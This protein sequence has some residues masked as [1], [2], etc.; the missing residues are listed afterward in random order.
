MAKNQRDIYETWRDTG[1]LPEIMTFI[2]DC[3]KKLV[4]QGEMC[5]HLG[6]NEAMFSRLKKRHPE[7]QFAMDKARMNLKEDLA[8]SLYKLAMRY[9][10][11]KETQD[12]EGKGSG[13]AQKRKIHRTKKEIGPDFKAIVYLLTKKFGREYSQRFEDF[14][15][16]EKKIEEAKEEWLNEQQTECSSDEDQCSP[17]LR[18]QSKEKR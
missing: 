10:F 4:T 7:I 12:I 17:R 14:Q 5:E 8:N 3:S 11:T 9:T 18:K 15:L 1:Q 2:S 6:I 16:A 13:Q